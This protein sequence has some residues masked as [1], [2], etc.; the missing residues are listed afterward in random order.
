MR[1][2]SKNELIYETKNKTKTELESLKLKMQEYQYLKDSEREFF[3]GRIMAV[4]AFKK[5]DQMLNA[6]KISYN[7]PE[8]NKVIT[9]FS[10]RNDKFEKGIFTL[11]EISEK[12]ETS[13]KEKDNFELCY[14]EWNGNLK[15]RDTYGGELFISAKGDLESVFVDSSKFIWMKMYSL[16]QELGDNISWSFDI[17]NWINS[18]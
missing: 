13:E 3:E 12:L 8:V 16:M 14:K 17:T 10:R 5:Q 1:Q 18:K 2:S 9:L 15:V 4:R 11:K 6:L 7:L